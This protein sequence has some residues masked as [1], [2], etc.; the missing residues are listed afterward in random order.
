MQAGVCEGG[1]QADRARARA[2]GKVPLVYTRKEGRYLCTQA[3]YGIY[4]GRPLNFP[5]SPKVTL[6]LLVNLATSSSTSS[7]VSCCTNRFLHARGSRGCQR[8]ARAT[9]GRE[10]Q[11]PAHQGRRAECVEEAAP[12]PQKKP[13][14]AIFLEARVQVVLRIT[15]GRGQPDR[16]ATRSHP[17]KAT[18]R[19]RRQLRLRVHHRAAQPAT[20]ARP[21]GS[22]WN[23]RVAGIESPRAGAVNTLSTTRAA[24][25]GAR[26]R[27]AMVDIDA[28]L[29]WDTPA[30][31]M[32]QG[33]K[34]LMR[35]DPESAR[36][37]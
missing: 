13:K 9:K 30:T 11:G 16:R 2:R 5:S 10:R 20:K 23:A 37:A 21:T 27:D 3:C 19:W 25:A 7:S 18:P 33:A 14:E 28:V 17:G 31:S 12:F 36:L 35:I 15:H 4:P 29:K 22:V 24:S 32:R 1:R 26:S 8:H 6:T 34:G